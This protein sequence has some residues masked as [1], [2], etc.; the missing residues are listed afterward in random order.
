MRRL[1]PFLAA[2]LF[3]APALPAAG[4]LSLDKVILALKPDKDP[5][6]MLAE[7]RKLG[8]ALGKLAG[9]PVEVIVPT[10]AAVILEGLKNGTI[11]LAYVSATEMVTIRDAGAGSVLLAGEISGQ[12]HYRSYWVALKGKPYAKVED[13]RGKPIA[14]SSLTSTSGFLIPMVDLKEKGLIEGADPESFFGKGNVW[15]G[16]GYVSAIE[17]VLRGEAEAAAVSYYVLDEDKYLTAEQKAKLVKIAEQG[18]VP[19]HV[20]AASSRLSTGDRDALKAALLA[21]REVAGAVSAEIFSADLVEV[22]GDA[23]L[24]PVEKALELLGRRKR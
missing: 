21:L 8:E 12:P 18:P 16:I 3:T 7:R 9:K 1:F 22:D 19:T 5:D 23:H 24:A 14:F 10:S 11:D 17:R 13:L 6:R 15:Y 2:L 20:V 4:P